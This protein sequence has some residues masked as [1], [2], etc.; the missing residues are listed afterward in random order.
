M[1]VPEERSQGRLTQRRYGW[2]L[3]RATFC[4]HALHGSRTML[5][6][7]ASTGRTSRS[8]AKYIPLRH[9]VP[10][11]LL[12]REPC[13]HPTTGGARK[14]KVDIVPP[15]HE[16][17]CV[18]TVARCQCQSV[19]SLGRGHGSYF[20]K[21]QRLSGR[22]L[23]FGLSLGSILLKLLSTLLAALHRRGSRLGCFGYWY[24]RGDL[25]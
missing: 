14:L 7:F 2:L 17:W 22:A 23:S 20:R 21:A 19:D 24:V 12:R 13:L 5:T 10:P 11:F 16:G 4:G 25:R 18:V 1:E 8:T 9:L 3:F 6:A 15:F